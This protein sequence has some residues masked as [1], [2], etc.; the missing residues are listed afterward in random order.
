MGPQKIKMFAT[1]HKAAKEIVG[2]QRSSEDELSAIPPG[3]KSPR[4]D[5]A[6]ILNT[7]P[8]LAREILALAASRQPLYQSSSGETGGIIKPR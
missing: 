6:Y 5:F 7:Q 2:N 4:H 1:A 3:C 8:S